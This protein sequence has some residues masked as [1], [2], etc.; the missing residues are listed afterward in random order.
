MYYGACW[1]QAI[2]LR[3]VDFWEKNVQKLA[4]FEDF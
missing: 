1:I 4:D 2:V 3:E